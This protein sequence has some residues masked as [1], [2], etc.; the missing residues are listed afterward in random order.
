MII[1]VSIL[2]VLH[3]NSDCYYCLPCCLRK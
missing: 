1:L 2:F 3:Y